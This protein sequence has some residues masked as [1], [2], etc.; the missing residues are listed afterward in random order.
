MADFISVRDQDSL[1]ILRGLGV[2][3]KRVIHAFDLAV[4]LPIIVN[5]AQEQ[6]RFILGISVLPYFTIYHGD[7]K[8]DYR[9]IERIA[10]G[11]NKWLLEEPLGEVHLIT[12]R[13]ERSWGGDVEIT[14][15]LATQLNP[16]DRVR[17]ISYSPDPS[18]MLCHVAQCDAFVAMRFHSAIFAY[19]CQLPMIVINYHPKCRALAREIGLPDQAVISVE[20]LMKGELDKLLLQLH[21]TPDAFRARL[22]VEEARRKAM[23]CLSPQLR[24]TNAR[25]GCCTR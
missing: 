16:R 23:A 7:I 2:S 18:R 17:L 3:S 25:N 4:L 14:E 13:G 24:G 1:S 9:M 15:C 11:V 19:M 10:V 20:D 21:H 6:R 8:N 12:I 22:P 5:R